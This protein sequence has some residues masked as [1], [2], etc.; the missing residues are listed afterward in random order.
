[1]NN[2]KEC[3][4]GVP[5]DWNC[6]ACS[7]AKNPQAVEG[8][9]NNEKDK[10]IEERVADKIWQRHGF[11]YD[12]VSAVKVAKEITAIFNELIKEWIVDKEC[13]TCRNGVLINPITC[14]LGICPE[15]FD[16]YKNKGTIPRPA[17]LSDLPRDSGFT[18]RRREG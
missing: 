8:C 10:S 15:C 18:P 2:E 14:P 12:R 4:H 9:M 13:P 3:K 7:D 5:L 17:A 1:M 11:Y 16:G 6:N